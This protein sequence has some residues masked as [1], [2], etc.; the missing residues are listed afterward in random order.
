MHERE[1][2]MSE[3]MVAAA[4]SSD[5]SWKVLEYLMEHEADERD[6]SRATGLH[7]AALKPMLEGMVDVKLLSRKSRTIP[8]GRRSKIYSLAES[9]SVGFPPRNYEYLSRA[10]ITSLVQS[11]GVRSAGTLLHDMAERMGEEMGDSIISKEGTAPLS[12]KEYAGRIVMRL[13]TDMKVYPR[14]VSVGSRRVIYE[15]SNCLFQE[16]ATE[17]PGLICDVMD[18]GVHSGLD[19][20]LGVTTTRLACKGHGDPTCRFCVTWPKGASGGHP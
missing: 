17:M 14:V 16:L 3:P 11:L 13:L 15:E 1:G 12:P 20:K 9:R 6:I 19:R 2:H 4:L 7:A 8:T 10:L 18:E 5:D